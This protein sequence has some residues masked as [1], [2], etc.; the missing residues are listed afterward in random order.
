V[1]L[2]LGP[3]DLEGQVREDIALLAM[4]RAF[5]A[6]ATGNAR[7]VPRSDVPSGSGF[8]RVMPAVLEH[9]MGLKVM[10]L[11]EGLGTRYLVLLYDTSTGELLALFDADELTR[12][13]TAATTALAARVIVSSPQR[14]L[15]LIGSGFEAVGELRA[16]AAL[17][18]LEEV[19]VYSPTQARR[20]RFAET[21]T[22]EL[23][24]PVKAVASS[25]AA[26]EDQAVVVLATK[27]STP[28]VPASELGTGTVVLSIGSTRLDLR[29]VD[30]ETFARAGTVVGD[31]P[32]QLELESGDVADALESGILTYDRVIAL[33]ELCAERA[34]VRTD[35]T[36]DL[37]VF[38]SIGTAI[39]DLAMARTVYEHA[40]EHGYGTDL[41]EVSRLKP[42]AQST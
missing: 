31:E 22:T 15:G 14:R 25:Q 36:H 37:V 18:P 21:M 2:F 38:K 7:L 11:A 41:G 3:E 17:W 24:I 26:V 13:R 23:E 35:N 4:E 8:L 16:L 32:H 42:F 40:V 29:E 10:T 28:V 19:L 5:A 6:E 33:C 27:S 20:E 30:R 9:V 1:T 34:T 12:Y 39:Q